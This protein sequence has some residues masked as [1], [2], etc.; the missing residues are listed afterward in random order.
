[1]PPMLSW[2]GRLQEMC[3]SGYSESS[4]KLIGHG[5]PMR[6]SRPINTDRPPL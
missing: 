2:A 3:E 1:M 4:S 6:R 5:A